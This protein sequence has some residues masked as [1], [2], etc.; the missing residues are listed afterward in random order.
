MGVYN[1]NGRRPKSEI[2]VNS[3]SL[4]KT[5]SQGAVSAGAPFSPLNQRLLSGRTSP[6]AYRRR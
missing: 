6:G 3:F 5:L 4:Q 1:R 2:P